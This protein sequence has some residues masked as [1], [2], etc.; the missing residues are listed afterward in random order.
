MEASLSDKRLTREWELRGIKAEAKKNRQG[1]MKTSWSLFANDLLSMGR[2][3]GDG[4]AAIAR[5][6]LGI[7][8]RRFEWK[9]RDQLLEGLVI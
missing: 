9:V 1:K 3:E 4:Q 7:Q 6:L 5:L 8:A 2:M